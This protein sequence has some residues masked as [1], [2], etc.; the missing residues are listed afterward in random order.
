MKMNEQY[1]TAAE[2]AHWLTEHRSGEFS[3]VAV[4]TITLWCRQNRL[5]GAFKVGT[6]I[7][8]PWLIPVAAL[9]TLEPP[10]RG[11]PNW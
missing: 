11:N 10:E 7:S 9:E 3:H 1:L 2:A 6:G 5:P 4:S 8:N